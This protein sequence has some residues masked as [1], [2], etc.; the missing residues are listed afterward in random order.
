MIDGLGAVRVTDFGLAGFVEEF[1][2]RD[3]GAGTPAYMAPEQL[4]G[5]E[6]SVK[7]DVY[8]RQDSPESKIL[9]GP[10]RILTR[11]KCAPSPGVR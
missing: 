9:P 4:A 10:A 3:V 7:S 11:E 5:R 1:S 8:V 6:V 2:G